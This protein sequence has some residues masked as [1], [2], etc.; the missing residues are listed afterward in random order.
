MIDIS[1]GLIQDAFHISKNS[2]LEI[3]FNFSN[4]PLP[5][6]SGVSKS[7]ILNSAL[8]GGDDYELLFSLNKNNLKKIM[9][10]AK[11][12]KL[13]ITNI[14]FLKKGRAGK[15]FDKNKE[16]DTQGFKHF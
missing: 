10:I 4:L 9:K 8:Y 5:L 2:N 11:N 16:V 14:G 3:H 13:K 1:D 6:I 12:L 7:E 15:I